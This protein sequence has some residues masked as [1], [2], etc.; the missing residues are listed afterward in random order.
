MREPENC[1]RCGKSLRSGLTA[2][3]ILSWFTEQ[4]ICMACSD[5]EHRIK[6]ALRESGQSD[7]EGCGYVPDVSGFMKRE[8]E[9]P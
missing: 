9:N 8:K 5:E 3:F 2:T 6:R 7:H 4:T 1:E